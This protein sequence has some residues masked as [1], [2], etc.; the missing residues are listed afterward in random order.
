VSSD[1][2][3]ALRL[4]ARSFSA[5]GH[6]LAG[7]LQTSLNALFVLERKKSV[8]PAELAS[9]LRSLEASVEALRT[10]LDRLLRLPEALHANRQPGTVGEVVSLAL[11]LLGESA[12]RVAVEAE[13]GAS[14]EVDPGS[15]ALALSELLAN[16][17]AAA[18]P[19]NPVSL[20]AG[21]EGEGLIAR[22]RNHGPDFPAGARTGLDPLF[23]LQPKTMGLGLAVARGVA[24]AH[25]GTLQLAH[26]AGTSTVTL[27]LPG[28]RP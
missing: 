14:V 1:R 12:S 16:A 27:T 13:R 2:E 19:A 21:A 11:R 26:E 24:F 3:A 15:A 17:L 22:V 4:V 28:A 8:E 23:T 7:P 10:R 18:G 5:V 9:P 25:G 6:E 20:S